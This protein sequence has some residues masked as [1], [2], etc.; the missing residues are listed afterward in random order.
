MTVGV[1][2]FK[3][4]QYTVKKELSNKDKQGEQKNKNVQ[5][6]GRFLTHLKKEP[7]ICPR[8]NLVMFIIK[9]VKKKIH[10]IRISFEKEHSN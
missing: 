6:M 5:K 9:F 3:K 8:C 7:P 1:Q 4:V 10:Q 2:F